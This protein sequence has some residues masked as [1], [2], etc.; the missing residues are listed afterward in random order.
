MTGQE[1]QSNSAALSYV[2][3]RLGSNTIPVTLTS[4]QQSSLKALYDRYKKISVR[5]SIRSTEASES[6]YSEIINLAL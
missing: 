2:G 4:E 6:N 5:M 1:N 3:L